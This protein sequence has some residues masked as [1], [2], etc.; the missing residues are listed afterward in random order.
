M[1]SV[2]PIVRSGERFFCLTITLLFEIK[3]NQA[4]TL[5]HVVDIFNVD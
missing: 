4:D 3:P 5:I 2:P 1:I